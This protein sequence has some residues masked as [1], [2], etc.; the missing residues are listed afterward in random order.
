M[1]KIFAIILS[2]SGQPLHQLESIKTY[3]TLALCEEARISLLPLLTIEAQANA[4]QPVHI[5][6]KCAP[7]GDPT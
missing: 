7:V 4:G 6:S 2:L 5:G 1:F 3:P